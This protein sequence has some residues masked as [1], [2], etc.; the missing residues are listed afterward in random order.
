[1]TRR[2]EGI[3]FTS[4]YY[5]KELD[6]IF[7]VLNN[8]KSILISILIFILISS[9]IQSQT[10]KTLVKDRL[11]QLFELAKTDNYEEAATY[12]VYRGDDDSRKWKDTCNFKNENEQKYVTEVCRD[13][14]Y[15]LAGGGDYTFGKFKTETE[16]E[17]TWYIWEVKF[18]KGETKSAY[19]AFLYIKN[20][21]SIGDID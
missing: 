1:L 3:F 8:M 6:L 18:S 12:I 17:G 15:L 11:V 10:K 9:Q 20:N 2:G 21:Y 4:L 13:I 19:F 14:K 7:I 5:S 16:S